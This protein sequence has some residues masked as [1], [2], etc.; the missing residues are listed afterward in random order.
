MHVSNRD[1]M[2]PP[3]IWHPLTAIAIPNILWCFM[4][5]KPIAP[6]LFCPVALIFRNVREITLVG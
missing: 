1:S 4:P 2:A 6:F 5:T 3:F